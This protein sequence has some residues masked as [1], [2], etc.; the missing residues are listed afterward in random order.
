MR[1]DLAGGRRESVM[2]GRCP[3]STLAPA[4]QEALQGAQHPGDPWLSVGAWGL[5][6]TVEEAPPDWA[7]ERGR[8]LAGVFGKD[9]A[10]LGQVRLGLAEIERDVLCERTGGG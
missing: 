3:R 9:Q 1:V 8:T 6:L 2:L 7:G 10:D 4:A 5:Q